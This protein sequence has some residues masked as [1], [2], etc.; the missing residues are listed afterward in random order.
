MRPVAGPGG[1]RQGAVAGA[2]RE[3]EAAFGDPTVFLERYL[4]RP[5]HIEIQVLADSH[6]NTVSLGER[7]CSVQRRHQKVLEEA[8]SVAVDAELRER[9]GAAAVA[10]AEAV[11]YVGAGT[12]EFML[13][14]GGGAAEFF[15]LEMNTRLQV[16]HPVT[17][18]VL[19][20]D[21]VAEQLRI[22]AGEAM[23][24]PRRRARRST[25]MRSRSAS[26]PR[27]PPPGSCPRRAPS[28]G[29]SISGAEP[30]AAPRRVA[31]G[32]AA[33]RLRRRGRHRRRPRLRPDARQAD[34]LGARPRDGRGAC[35]RRRS[36]APSSTAW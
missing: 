23:S 8:P 25:A 9:L 29:S 13:D 15:F 2:R 28:S 35:S 34:R 18:M 30:F 26:T 5:R 7:E 17:E 21:L 6:G 14:E 4:Q 10:A 31:A 36:P 1:P 32:R 27:T 11:G 19:G 3:A 33:A 24:R 20:I 22:A 12:V 16:E